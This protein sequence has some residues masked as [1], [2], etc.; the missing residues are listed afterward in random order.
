MFWATTLLRYVQASIVLII[1]SSFVCGASRVRGVPSTPAGLPPELAPDELDDV[2]GRSPRCALEHAQQLCKQLG[3]RQRPVGGERLGRH[4]V[5]SMAVHVRTPSHAISD[6]AARATIA[7]VHAPSVLR[8]CR[9]G[10]ENGG[11]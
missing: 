3:S 5:C 1:P 10:S 8:G 9:G 7:V 4:R 2:L 6:A 11:R